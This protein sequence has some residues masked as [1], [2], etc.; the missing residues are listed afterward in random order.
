MRLFGC[1]LTGFAKAAVIL[2]A[3]LLVAIGLCGV[4]GSI[5]ARHHWSLLGQPGIPKTLLG[6]MLIAFDLLGAAA[7]VI[8]LGGLLLVVV[9]WPISVIYRKLMRTDQD[10]VHSL[11]DETSR[12]S[13]DDR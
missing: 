9:G 1:E 6:T 4:S 2:V 3:M 11:F 10:H 7:I 12:K 5:E 13:E 8:S